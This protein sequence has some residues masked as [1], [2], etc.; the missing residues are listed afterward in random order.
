MRRERII[1]RDA[2]EVKYRRNKEE[3]KK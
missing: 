2:V 1:N 3:I